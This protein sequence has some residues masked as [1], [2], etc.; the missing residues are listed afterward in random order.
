MAEFCYYQNTKKDRIKQKRIITMVSDFLDNTVSARIN[1]SDEV[2]VS[3]E[4][5]DLERVFA[6][7]SNDIEM[8]SVIGFKVRDMVDHPNEDIRE[9]GERLRD[10]YGIEFDDNQKVVDFSDIE[11]TIVE[12]FYD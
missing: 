6:E 12:E 9:V 1:Y 4:P 5:K 10:V 3:G 2:C 8:S 7:L 11:N